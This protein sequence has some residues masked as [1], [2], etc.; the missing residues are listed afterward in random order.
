MIA[1]ASRGGHR[2]DTMEQFHDDMEGFNLDLTA[3]DVSTRSRHRRST[4]QTAS[5]A[6]T[7]AGGP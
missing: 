6:V 5:A 1:S 7:I 3:D 4:T 2:H